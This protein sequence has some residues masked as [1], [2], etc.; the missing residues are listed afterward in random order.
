MIT[1][2]YSRK[3][4]GYSIVDNM[5]A[6][7]VSEEAIVLYNNYRPHQSLCLK[8]SNQVNQKTQPPEAVGFI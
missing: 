1:D 8:K 2:A 4:M 5:E 7:T 3:M 6:A